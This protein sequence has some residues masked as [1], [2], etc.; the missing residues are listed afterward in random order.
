MEWRFMSDSTGCK[1]LLTALVVA[2]VMGGLG[3]AT[4]FLTHTVLVAGVEASSQTVVLEVTATPLP[5]DLALPATAEPGDP[6]AVPDPMGSASPSSGDNETFALFWEA[7]E[8]IQRD[9]YGELPSDEELTYGAIRGATGTLDDPYTAFVEPARAEHRRQTDGSSYEG[10]GALVTMR[11][12]QLVIVEPFQDGPADSAGVW[13]G[14]VVIQVDDTPIQ[15]ISLYEAIALILGPA[16]TQ[17]RLTIVREGEEPFEVAITRD[18]IDIPL[19]ESE[20]REDGIA[21]VSLFQFNTG[22]TAKLEEA[23]EQLLAQNP[24]GLIL[25]LRGNPGGYLNEAALTAGLFLPR[26]SVVLIERTK[27]EEIVLRAEDFGAGDPIARDITMVV[28]VNPGSA[29]GS[30]IVAGALQDYGRAILIGETTLGKGSVQLLHPLSN[31]AELRVTKAR[32]FTPNDR[33]IHGEGL[34]PDIEVELTAE[35]AEAELDPQLDR[36]VEY[37]LTGE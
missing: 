14:D 16:G 13:A 22:A 35:D 19:V 37:L 18:K 31:G 26:D 8:I 15:N 2:I 17:V 12:G 29:S 4:G 36:A 10:I 34:T 21:Y 25:D 30:E 5:E 32:W 1:V 9:F 3:F 33:P 23:I 28:L 11:E 27:E 7:W 24:T 6:E 20:M